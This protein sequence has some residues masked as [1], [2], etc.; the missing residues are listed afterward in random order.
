MIQLEGQPQEI[1][2][3]VF[4]NHD[5]SGYILESQSLHTDCETFQLESYD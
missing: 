3:Q 2:A 4:P 5:G 1:N